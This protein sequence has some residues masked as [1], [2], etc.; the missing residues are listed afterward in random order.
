MKRD[1]DDGRASERSRRGTIRRG[2]DDVERVPVESAPRN[3]R[4]SAEAIAGAIERWFPIAAR[5]LPWRRRRTPYRVL[6]SE[7][8]LQQTQV[9]R[10]AERFPRFM[11]RFPSART[12]AASPLDD[13]LQEW[14]G[15][16]YYRRARLLHEAARRI[17]ERHGGRV[18][19]DEADLRDLPGVGA[20]TAGA[21]ASI[22]H[23]R[24][25]AIVDGNVLR[26]LVRVAG[27]EVAADDPGTIRWCWSR[28]REIVEA[29]RS[30]AT[31]NEG[32]ME[33]GA[34]VCTPRGP[35][36]GD[37]P[38]AD[39]C[40]A[41][42]KGDPESLPLPKRRPRRIRLVHHVLLLPPR[43]SGSGRLV[44]VRRRPETGLWASMWE[45]PSIE[46]P[47]RMRRRTIADRLGVAE[48]EV[49]RLDLLRHATTHRDLEFVVLRVP[50][51]SPEAVRDLGELVYVPE[52]RLAELAMSVPQRRIADAMLASSEP[53]QPSSRRGGA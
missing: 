52:T 45:F 21:V 11:R 53:A 23:G 3:E 39:R 44:A 20:Y 5:P 27:R 47:R 26:V 28:S 6:V 25:A 13:V 8:M 31:L 16:G 29:A 42:A 12:L 7:T 18:P 43:G 51:P 41:R 40:V 32:L 49:R 50:L 36:C 37:C 4:T 15:L 9:A 1:P 10:V 33:L 2:G 35:A 38:L 46:T 48:S 14:E 30:P 24:P 22:A 17:V 19:A 34:T